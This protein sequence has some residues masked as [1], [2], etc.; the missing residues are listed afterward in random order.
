MSVLAFLQADFSSVP[1]LIAVALII[2]IGYIAKAIFGRTKIPEVL[3]LIA[4][5]LLLV[6]V[7]HLLPSNYVN[8]LRSLTSIFGDLALVVIMYNGG[9]VIGVNRALFKS[10]RG[11]LLGFLDTLLP[12][13]GVSVL[14]WALFQWPIIYG[15]IL[16]AILGETSTVIVAPLLKKIKITADMYSTL[17]IETTL[18]SVFSILFFTLLV[19]FVSGQTLTVGSFAS[20][21]VDYISIAIAFGLIMGFVWIVVQNYIKGARGYLATIAMA[22][23]LYGIVDLFKGAAAVSVL[24]F[25]IM[26]S[27]YKPIANFMRF[28]MDAKKNEIGE[29][30]AVERDIEF[31]IT[32]FFFVFIGMIA[33]ISVQSFIYA[34]AVTGLLVVIRYVEV[35]YVLDDNGVYEDLGFALMQRGTVVAILAA[36]LF[37]YGGT[38]ANQI[39]YICFMIIILTNIIASVLLSRVKVKVMVTPQQHA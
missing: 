34:I 39:F 3:I 2:I 25:A 7:G 11:V 29:R 37:S 32:T 38:Y 4:I 20:F 13:V 6:P 22:I 35:K 23:L 15:A 19:S 21:T 10:T 5:G 26:L 17:L 30:N 31:L 8:S 12:T 36:I 24:I 1:T 33:I 28:K 18:N 16:G 14:M 9:K 27:N